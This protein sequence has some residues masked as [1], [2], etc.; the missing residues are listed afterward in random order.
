MEAVGG[1]TPVL[2]VL[3]EQLRKGF[4]ENYQMFFLVPF[5]P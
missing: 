1:I 3:A 4:R 2:Y 5:H